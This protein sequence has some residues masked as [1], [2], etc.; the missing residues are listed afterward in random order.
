MSRFKIPILLS[1]ALAAF[2][3]TAAPVQAQRGGRGGGGGVARGGGGYARGGYGYGRGGY[4][5]G[6]GGYG[7]GYGRGYGW[8]GYGWGGYGWGGIYP[9]YGYGYGYP[10]GY[11]LGTYGYAGSYP[12]YGYDYSVPTYVYPDTSA[13][14]TTQ[15]SA[16]YAPPTGNSAAIHLRVPSSATVWVDDDRTQQTGPERNFATPPLTPGKTFEYQVKAKW[17]KD[18]KP[19]EQTRTVKVRANET[20]NVDF[21]STTSN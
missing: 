21:L 17:M 10:Y 3:W 20:S 2:A 6:R 12:S 5:Y 16:Y 19:V 4:G 7:Y 15:Q 13:T 14:I 11:D 18:G 9:Y 1:L 8:G